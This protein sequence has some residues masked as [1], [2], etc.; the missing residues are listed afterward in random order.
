[1]PHVAE[2]W[3]NNRYDGIGRKRSQRN[4]RHPTVPSTSAHSNREHLLKRY[5]FVARAVSVENISVCPWIDHL[6]GIGQFVVGFPYHRWPNTGQGK[7]NQLSLM[8]KILTTYRWP[9]TQRP[10]GTTNVRCTPLLFGRFRLSAAIFISYHRSMMIA[11]H[12]TMTK[13]GVWWTR[14]RTLE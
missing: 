3:E 10:S 1:M 14:G 4:L 6:D 2:H 5:M 12:V 11:H 13:A 8:R 7:F 9:F